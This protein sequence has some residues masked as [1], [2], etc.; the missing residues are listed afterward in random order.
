MGQKINPKGFRIG[1][2]FTWS[3]RWFAA[4]GRYKDL[5]L[6]DARLRELLFAKLKISGT[7]S[8]GD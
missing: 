1:T 2:T 6:Q 4:G 3:S 7:R 8:C 5:L